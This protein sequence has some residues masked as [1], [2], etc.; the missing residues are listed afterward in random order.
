MHVTLFICK[1]RLEN[2]KLK[3]N[4]GYMIVLK[5]RTGFFKNSGQ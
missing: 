5:I 4:L 2:Y 3:V 1:E